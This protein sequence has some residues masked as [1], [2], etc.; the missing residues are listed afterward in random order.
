M[1]SGASESPESTPSAAPPTAPPQ[2]P[3]GGRLKRH[4]PANRWA[5]RAVWTVTGV[6]GLWA[7][8]WLAVPPLLKWQAQKIASEQLGRAVTIGEVD[9]KPWTLELTLRNLAVA[10]AA[11]APP[12]VQIQRAYVDAD[13]ESLV[14]LA[15]VMDAI[16]VDAPVLRLK[17]LGNGHYDIDDILAKFAARPQPA[18]PGDPARFALYN[19]QVQGGQIDFDDQTVGRQHQVRDLHLNVPFISNLPSQR[20]IKVQPKL[21]FVAN[22]S[23]FDSS[24]SALPFTDSRQT[25]AAFRFSKLDLAP[26]LGYVP[27]GLPI[28]LEA[29]TLDADLRLGF[30]QTPQ[31]SLRVLGGLEVSGLKAKDGQ[32]ADAVAFDGLKV[33]LADVRPLEGKIHLAKVDLTNP[34]VAVR[35]DKGGRINL[36]V[37]ESAAKTPQTVAARADGSR[38][39]GTLDAKSPVSAASAAPPAAPASA[40]ASAS[41]LTPASPASEAARRASGASAAAT[42]AKSAAPVWKVQVDELAVHGGTVDVTDDTTLSDTSAAATVRL[43]EVELA[44][45]RIAWP[46]AQAVAFNGSAALV[47]TEGLTKAL[48]APATAK[49]ATKAA[50]K[51]DAKAAKAGG[52]AVAKTDDAK[53]GAQPKAGAKADTPPHL[54]TAAAPAGAASAPVS[55]VH[56]SA[57]G[58]VPSLEF[59]GTASLQGAEVNARIAALPLALAA[60][61]LAP[62]LVP[63]LTGNLDAHVGLQWAPPKAVDLPPELKVAA[64]RLV[65]SHLLL[66]DE[67]GATAPAAPARGARSR[68]RAPGVL[69]SVDEL[70]LDQVLVDLRSRAVTVGKVALQKPQI[71]VARDAEQR[72]MF[73]R[74]LRQP[75]GEPAADKGKPAAKSPAAASKGPKTDF[76]WKVQVAELA[77]DDG[78]VGWQD[79][80]MAEP[81]RAELTQLHLTAK[82]IDLNA[83][84][85]MQVALVTRLGAGRSDP[86][87]LSWRGQVGV[88]PALSAQGQVDAVRLPVHAFE[89]YFGEALNIDILR[90]DTSFKGKVDFT[91]TAQGPRARVTGDALVEELRTHSRP[92]SAASGGADAPPAPGAPAST[93]HRNLGG[94]RTTTATGPARPA[95]A[96]GDQASAVA[97]ASG[98]SQAPLAPGAGADRAGGLGE[99]LL[100]WKQ[101]RLGGVDVQLDPGKPLQVDVKD[102][103]LSDFYARLLI[104]PNGRINL[105]DLVKSKDG[106]A[107]VTAAAAPVATRSAA[108]G[109]PA[110]GENSGDATGSVAA[111]AGPAT[112][113]APIVQQ[114]DPNAPVIRFGPVKLSNGK[115]FFSDRFIR[116]NY[117]ADLT[118]LNGS[119]SAFS[120]VPPGGAPQMADLELTGRAE[121]T[122]G[123]DIRGKL[124]P[125][126]K[127]LALDIQAKVSDLELPPL[128]PYSVKYAGHGIERGKLSMDVAYKVEPDGRLTATNKLVLNQLEFGEAVAGAPAS[129]PVK[130]ATALLADS[131][132]VIDLDLP[133]SGSLN[134]PQF[135]VGP[136]IV[137]AIINIIGKAITAPFTLLA[138]ALG[139]GPGDDMS[140][141][142]FAPGS[143]QLNAKA[144]EQL[145]KVAKA[146]TDRP[147]LKLTV[148]GTSSLAA[149]REG[150]KRERLKT[151]VAAEKRANQGAASATP[152]QAAS[153]SVAAAAPAT[154]AS[155]PAGA[156]SGAAAAVTVTDAEYPQLLRRLYRRA[157]LPGKPRNAIGL[158][159]DIPVAEM[160]ALLMA[161]I[162]VGEDAMRQLA[163][164]RGVAVKDY[165]AARKLPTDRVFLG[166]ARSGAQ[167]AKQATAADAPASA[168]SGAEGATRSAWSPRAELNLSAR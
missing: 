44:A 166:A 148:V 80:A 25:D 42:G 10:G 129:L 168:A 7:V 56:A 70:A 122:A 59:Q 11:G 32:G 82:Q 74:W 28:K 64:D 124:N 116:P 136:I 97:R 140:N 154:G 99:E 152:A 114:V 76:P 120:S 141:V 55:T 29:A 125:L 19:I 145:D 31:P 43:N 65:L 38:A 153:E 77:V 103:Q 93:T 105:Q 126:A 23:A 84:Q 27:A 5:R 75:A 155:A 16:Q 104:H 47:G 149:E 112:V 41:V 159:K 110:A 21:A 100:S 50:A 89:P 15:P 106:D 63:Q 134:D 68:A 6:L 137:K 91:Q 3:V 107:T 131:K 52:K 83:A 34:H 1:T 61:Y 160:E 37:S 58:A 96:R 157:D 117:S 143:A 144:R 147:T 163:T 128:S 127:P 161:Q 133:I 81:V 138:R 8:G 57:L 33:Q 151:L 115:V 88:L 90:A 60:P 123:L 62:H 167:P 94:S 46:M 142:A 150:Y 39:E 156:A 12:Q 130:L 118:E 22:G 36:L 162:E 113:A 108:V 40:T 45:Q 30:E 69:G 86:G 18:E 53:A 95:A 79:L 146:L 78:N 109:Q 9:F 87:R 54:Q 158:Q 121:G 139:G 26:Y 71:D 49:P 13:I 2:R 72:L 35:R 17:H 85:P 48:P 67:S 24:A 135:S 101:L 20:E 111:A 132:G 73:E 119:L 51:A 14:R 92:G 4:L 98:G 164:Q 102:T 165:L 66:T